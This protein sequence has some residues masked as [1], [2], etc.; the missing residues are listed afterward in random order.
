MFARGTSKGGALRRAFSLELLGGDYPALHGLR[1]LA[2]L[3]VLQ[4][5]ATTVLRNRH[6]PISKA[7]NFFSMNVF[8]GMDLF[9]VLSGF[10]IGS[11]LIRA[12]D[13]GRA[14]GILRFYGRRAFRIIPLYYVVL[15]ALALF[16]PRD[17][18]QGENLVYEYA[19]LTNYRSGRFVMNWGWSLCVEEHFYLLVPFLVAGLA[20]LRTHRSR[21]CALAALWLLCLCARLA[22]YAEL[23]HPSY[24]ELFARLYSKTHTRFDVLVA[25]VLVAYAHHHFGDAISAALRKRAWRLLAWGAVFVCLALL[26]FPA[27]GTESAL[28]HIFAWGTLTSAMYVPLLLLLLHTE[29]A[30]GRFLSL[31]VFRRAATLGY[32]VY[33]V[34]LPLSICALTAARYSVESRAIPISLAW[35]AT[36][37][38]TILLSAACAY[39]LHL[40]VEKPALRLRDRLVPSA[41]ARR[42]SASAPRRRE[43]DGHRHLVA[44][45]LGGLDAR[46]ELLA[47]CRE[48]HLG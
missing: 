29:T 15:T 34:H 7:F 42:A 5:H 18:G 24:A 9:F 40:A 37:A 31:P 6:F 27:F 13:E 2:I 47:A 12:L 35:P 26:M 4:Y 36:Y 28:F 21:L 17:P 16:V 41:A 43:G 23:P 3:S 22:V 46:R 1:V 14:T 19:Y 45:E 48:L 38:L 8:F 33:L 44:S 25:G 10:L 11:M 20:A 32:G 30:F 39:A